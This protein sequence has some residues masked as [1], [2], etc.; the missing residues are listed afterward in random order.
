MTSPKA[1]P[2]GDADRPVRRWGRSS[3]LG[4][5]AMTL[6]MLALGW[7]AMRS[8]ARAPSPD[9]AREPAGASMIALGDELLS[10]GVL[11]GAEDATRFRL[12]GIAVSAISGRSDARFEDVL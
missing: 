5:S 10:A 12:D 3:V 11:D 9:A 7:I 2:D 4:A 1:Q 8:G 6:A